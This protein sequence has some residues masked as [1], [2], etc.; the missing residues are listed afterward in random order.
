MV[1]TFTKIRPKKIQIFNRTF[2]RIVTMDI[3]LNRVH[4]QA[5]FHGKQREREEKGVA[6]R[7]KER[8]L[9]GSQRLGRIPVWSI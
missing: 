3:Y 5:G 2:R 4:T 7:D 6:G 8:N 9:K 1:W